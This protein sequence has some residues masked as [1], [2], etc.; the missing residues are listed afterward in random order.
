MWSAC[1][2]TQT[3]LWC[4]PYHRYATNKERL[5][6]QGFNTNFKQVISYQLAKQ[7]EIA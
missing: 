6:L 3:G 1:L 2:N 5:M 7:I 4:V